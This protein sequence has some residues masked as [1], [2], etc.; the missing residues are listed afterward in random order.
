MPSEFS[1]Q[2]SNFSHSIFIS[3]RHFFVWI[4]PSL[5]CDSCTRN[6]DLLMIGFDDRSNWGILLHLCVNAN[7]SVKNISNFCK[8]MAQLV[9][10]F[11]FKLPI[12]VYNIISTSHFLTHKYNELDILRYSFEGYVHYSS[13]TKTKSQDTFLPFHQHNSGEEKLTIISCLFV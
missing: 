5:I 2:L 11:K 7:G 13:L 8:K 10:A 4:M 6:V 1:S 12:Y 3:S 9:H